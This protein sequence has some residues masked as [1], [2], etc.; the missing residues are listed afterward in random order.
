MFY[1]QAYDGE[2]ANAEKVKGPEPALKIL[3]RKFMVKG[4]SCSY[5]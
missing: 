5:G 3:L 4:V 1:V 2:V